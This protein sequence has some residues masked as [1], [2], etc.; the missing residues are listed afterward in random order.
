M[1]AFITLGNAARYLAGGDATPQ[2]I[3]MF[4][5]LLESEAD[6]LRAVK[7]W[8]EHTG[9]MLPG[10]VSYWRP[11]EQWRILKVAFVAWCKANGYPVEQAG[12]AETSSAQPETGRRAQQIAGI[13]DTIKG[14]GWSPMQ[15]PYGGKKRLEGLCCDSAPGMFSPDAF[16]HA[17]KEAL[18]KGLVRTSGHDTYAKR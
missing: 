9:D 18:R 6:S 17:W 7:T 5:S 1:S 8:T 11:P 12:N 14:L 15:I 2:E 13:L 16:D 10:G 3:A 4:A